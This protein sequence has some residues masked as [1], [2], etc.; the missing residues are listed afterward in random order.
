MPVLSEAMKLIDAVKRA[1]P[2]AFES[3]AVRRAA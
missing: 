3:V 1:S 2:R